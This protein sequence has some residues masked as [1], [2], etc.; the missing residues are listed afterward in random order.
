MQCI[1]IIRMNQINIKISYKN[2][3]EKENINDNTYI[4]RVPGNN[5]L[6]KCTGGREG[7]KPK[8]RNMA[9]PLIKRRDWED[10]SFSILTIIV[11]ST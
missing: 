1:P 7:I 9:V 8:K 6:L 5:S 11:S 3:I 10:D 4:C 2:L